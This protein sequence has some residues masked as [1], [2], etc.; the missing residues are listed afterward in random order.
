MDIFTSILV[1]SILG[2]I[3][4]RILW[5]IIENAIKKRIDK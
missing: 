1:A 5:D 4:S 3:I 2:T